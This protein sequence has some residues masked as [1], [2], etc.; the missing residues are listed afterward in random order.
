MTLT[1]GP[2]GSYTQIVRDLS[3]K[4]SCTGMFINN[5]K[6][7]ASFSLTRYFFTFHTFCTN[8]HSYFPGQD[9]KQSAFSLLIPSSDP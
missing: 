6:R 9:R 3:H 5:S 1:Y 8:R 7:I 2:Y 4:S